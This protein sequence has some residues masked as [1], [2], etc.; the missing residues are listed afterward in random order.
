[1]I[2]NVGTGPDGKM[3]FGENGMSGN[4]RDEQE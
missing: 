4:W 3:W 2:A 1:M